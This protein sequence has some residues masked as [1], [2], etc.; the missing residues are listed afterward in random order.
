MRSYVVSLQRNASEGAPEGQAVFRAYL[1]RIDAVHADVRRWVALYCDLRWPQEG[2]IPGVKKKNRL[3]FQQRMASEAQELW[4]ELVAHA[5][6]G[7]WGHPRER[8]IYLLK[9]QLERMEVNTGAWRGVFPQLCNSVYRHLRFVF[10]DAS[11][12]MRHRFQ[13]TLA[14]ESLSAD[15]CAF[16]VDPG[17]PGKSGPERKRGLMLL[18]D[19]VHGYY[20]SLEPIKAMYQRCVSPL[21]EFLKRCKVKRMRKIMTAG[22][23]TVLIFGLGVFI[24]RQTD[25]DNR[26]W[27]VMI[28]ELKKIIKFDPD[29][30]A[31]QEKRTYFRDQ[32]AQIDDTYSP[33]QIR[34]HID[35]FYSKELYRS[36]E[37]FLF[38][39]R[40]ILKGFFMLLAEWKADDQLKQDVVEAAF[41]LDGR[42]ARPLANIITLFDQQII[43]EGELREQILRMRRAFVA[44]NVF[45]FTFIILEDDVP[46]LF[47]FSEM[48][49]KKYVLGEEAFQRMQLDRKL[50]SRA[51]LWPGVAYIV[52]GEEYPFADRSGYFEGGF[53][54]VFRRFS[55]A[56]VW[57]VYHE[58]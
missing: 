43:R 14:Q 47:L 12:A 20:P 56:V 18:E 49:I 35:E 53:A 51:A 9:Q 41:Y 45:P 21:I 58:V 25:A 32:I 23:L 34:V 33:Q 17:W 16:L 24:L 22:L 55:P 57:T 27:R 50:Y 39:C 19:W 40:N 5:Q 7:S 28:F 2:R 48:V 30:L 31:D 1:E 38:F 42:I 15:S 52:E 26:I 54:V 13:I 44:Y 4:G 8:E 10:M 11:Y 6:S 37:G 3:A 29:S 36:Q 46:Y